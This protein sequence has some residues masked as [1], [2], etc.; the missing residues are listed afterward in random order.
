M[1]V[2]TCR[3]TH[4]QSLTRETGNTCTD[5]THIHL[6]NTDEDEDDDFDED[7]EEGTYMPRAC[8]T[9]REIGSH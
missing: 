8:V 2:S 4:S 3:E 1:R 7:L 5:N 6:S 9:E